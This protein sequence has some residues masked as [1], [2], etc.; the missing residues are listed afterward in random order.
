MLLLPGLNILRIRIFENVVRNVNDKIRRRLSIFAV[1]KCIYS[2]KRCFVC[3][4]VWVCLRV[5][6]TV[7]LSVLTIN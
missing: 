6:V 1:N 7:F 3:V 4:C 2:V 5:G